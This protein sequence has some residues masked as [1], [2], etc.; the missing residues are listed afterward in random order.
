MS[1]AAMTPWPCPS[2]MASRLSPRPWSSASSCRSFIGSEPVLSTKMSGMV[3]AES[4]KHALRSKAGG[5]TKRWPMLFVTNFWMASMTLSRRRQRRMHICCSP[6]S[7]LYGAGS[8][9]SCGSFESKMAF[10]VAVN[11]TKC[12]ARPSKAGS[13][14]RLQMPSQSAG[15]IHVGSGFATSRAA[16]G[17]TPVIRKRHSVM[18]TWLSPIMILMFIRKLKSSLCCSKSDRQMLQ[19]TE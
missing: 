15:S 8:F 12:C 16:S 5:I 19:Y 14:A 4:L 17:D 2:A 9:R 10:H 18:S 1:R 6:L 11:S 7:A 3:G 13:V